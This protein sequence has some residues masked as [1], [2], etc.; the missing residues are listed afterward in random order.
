MENRQVQIRS[1]DN[2]IS[3][4]LFVPE[5][6]KGIIIFAH[7]SGSSRFSPRNNFIAT[8][9]QSDGFATLLIDLL[10]QEEES[11]DLVTSEFRFDIDL[12]CQRLI[13]ATKYVSLGSATSQLPVG[14]FGSSTGAS[15][16][17]MAAA[18]SYE[19]KAIVSRGGRLDLAKDY[20]SKIKSPTLLIVGELDEEV[21]NINHQ[22]LEDMTSANDKNVI[23][24]PEASHLFEEPGA[25]EEVV[26][27]SRDWFHR[28]LPQK[29]LLT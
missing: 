10:T 9:L 13:D 19:I 1:E 14:Y 6:A 16:A 3:G 28:F 20:L 18:A 8:E 17:L 27:L 22:A 4:N 26:R 15:A 23:V 24:V 11:I 2:Y 29:H 21:V 12:L 7:G 25:L 5:N